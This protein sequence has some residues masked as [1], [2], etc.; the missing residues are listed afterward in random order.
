[1]INAFTGG[2]AEKLLH[3]TVLSQ[4]ERGADVEVMVLSQ[5]NNH[6]LDTVKSKGIQVYVSNSR[7]L[8][9]PSQINELKKV[10]AK[11]DY[12][13]VHVHLFPALYWVALC[14]LFVNK[15]FKLVYTEHS[16]HNRRRDKSYF[17][18][19]ESIIYKRYQR[20]F[21]IS[22]GTKQN[23]IQWIPSTD[24]KARIIPN[25]INLSDY[26]DAK[27]YDRSY[28][29]ANIKKNDKLIV[30][31]ARFDHQKDHE[32]LIKSLSYLDDSFKLIL[33]GDGGWTENIKLITI[34]E[35]VHH[36]VSFLGFRKDIPQILKTADIFVLSS[37]WEGFGLVAVEA[38]ASGIPVLVS[39]VT[40]LRDVVE[41]K[42]MIFSQGDP[43]MLAKKVRSILID[44]E[45]SPKIIN[46]GL[47][48]AKEF[49]IESM[50]NRL[51]QEYNTLINT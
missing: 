5:Q 47:N 18:H 7:S 42:D 16:T 23:L 9:S 28:L 14:S 29:F 49:S 20:I 43:E 36:R 10:I 33:V 25:G 50:V 12:D 27:P 22:E 45:K 15:D 46:Y 19:I 34:S 8:H 6:Y 38:M 41:R 40:G 44:E 39:D 4:K 2:G 30:M 17:R 37:H 51:E 24:K 26:T 35:G 48:R 13:I 1:M 32:T 21:C 3:D 11:G 31:I